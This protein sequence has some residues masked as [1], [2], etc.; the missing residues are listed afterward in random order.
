MV[1]FEKFNDLRGFGRRLFLSLDQLIQC[2]TTRLDIEVVLGRQSPSF[3]LRLLRRMMTIAKEADE[4]MRSVWNLTKK[5]TKKVKLR[6]CNFSWMRW[7]NGCTRKRA[8]ECK[9]RSTKSC[10]RHIPTRSTS[11]LPRSN[12]S[13]LTKWYF[14]LLTPKSEFWN[15][16]VFFLFK[17]TLF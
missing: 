12:C 11:T 4:R 14:T 5:G 15:N 10:R 7:T 13:T 16:F 17:T 3:S 1:L 8:C 9:R 6:F 2:G